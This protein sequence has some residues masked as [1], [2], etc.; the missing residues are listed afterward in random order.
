[1]RVKKE[2]KVV[3]NILSLLVLLFFFSC[4]QSNLKEYDVVVYGGTSAGVIAAVTA[5]KMGKSVIVVEDHEHL[6][7]MSASGL[8]WTDYGKEKAIQGVAREFYQM[9]G[10]KYNKDIAWQHEPHVAEEVFMELMS[11]YEVPFLLKERIDLEDGVDMLDMRI[12][13]I[14]LESGRVLKGKMFVDASYEG[15]LMALAGV[16]FTYGRESEATYGEDL[17]GVR[18]GDIDRSLQYTQGDKDHFTVEVDPYIVPGDPTSGV[19]AHVIDLGLHNGSGR[20]VQGIG[21]RKTQAYTF[22]LCVSKDP[23]NMIPFEKPANYDEKEFEL[24]FRIFEAGD[25]RLP[26]KI[27]PLPNNKFDINSL[28]GFSTDGGML[29]WSFPTGDYETRQKVIES[30]I[31]YEQGIIWTLA[32]HPRVP[33][34]I[35]DE[36]KQYGL[37]KDEFIRNEGWPYEIYIREARRMVSD[38]VMT[39]HHAEGNV[40]VEDP[41]AEASFGMDSH[42]VQIFVNE[43]GHV[44][45]EG[46]IWRVPP[47]AYGISY[48][49]IVPKKGE[50]E[51]LFVPVCLSASHVAHGSIRMEPQFMM[52]GQAAVLAASLAID[53][54][55]SA[56]EVNYSQLIDLIKNKNAIS[57]LK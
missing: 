54:N 7:G 36:V 6:G 5:K 18:R 24:L 43:E 56:Q 2:N 15:D 20:L 17:N 38:Y 14:E 53:E 28:H 16:S 52:L 9:L 40:E 39:Q 19:I 33:Q 22:R 42:V 3:K 31:N 35:R 25:D 13:K 34:K 32:N 55:V 41:V 51:N 21:D 37:A 27:D 23:D 4:Q 1:M 46:V 12:E 29:N 11:K 44:H 45:R 57:V 47:K 48:R 49:S 50:V 10:A 26:L 30:Q 8:G